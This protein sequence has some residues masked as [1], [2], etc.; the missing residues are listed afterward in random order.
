MIDL[1]LKDQSGYYVIKKPLS[2][3]TKGYGFVLDPDS[4]QL[5]SLVPFEIN[6]F[7]AIKV[8]VSSPSP[9]LFLGKAPGGKVDSY[10]EQ[11]PYTKINSL[12][13]YPTKW[14]PSFSPGKYVPP[15]PSEQQ[16]WNSTSSASGTTE[17]AFNSTQ[18]GKLVIMRENGAGNFHISILVGIKGLLLY[19]LWIGLLLGG[20]TVAILGYKLLSS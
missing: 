4:I 10:L 17:W 1:T 9:D 19:E 12:T 20:L 3:Q 8:I 11:I 13:I 7:T 16:F 6:S 5:T 14:Q 15:P 2:H 18:K